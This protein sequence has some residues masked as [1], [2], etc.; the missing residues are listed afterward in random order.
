MA[1]IYFRRILYCTDLFII[2]LMSSQDWWCN[3]TRK[4][5]IWFMTFFTTHSTRIKIHASPS[6]KTNKQ[7]NIV[8]CSIRFPC[9]RDWNFRDFSQPISINAEVET[10]IMLRQLPLTTFLIYYLLIMPPLGVISGKL[11][12]MFIKTIIKN[13]TFVTKKVTY[14]KCWSNFIK[15]FRRN[16]LPSLR[17]WFRLVQI[18]WINHLIQI[19]SPE[20]G[21]S[22]LVGNSPAQYNSPEN[23][24][25]SNTHRN[26]CHVLW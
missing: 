8:R 20:Y 21:G 14:Q 1:C 17:R 23:Y 5:N 10:V 2:H 15:T 25:W 11:K 12:K 9:Y 26:N 3:P 19:Q 18:R 16:A 4:R 6:F 7:K 13:D 22:N 24:H